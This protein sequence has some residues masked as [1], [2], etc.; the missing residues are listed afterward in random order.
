MGKITCGYEA[1]LDRRRSSNTELTAR[2]SWPAG[3]NDI[4]IA[5]LPRRKILK[6]PQLRK[7]QHR[8][9]FTASATL[10]D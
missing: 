4:S 9:R 5:L 6:F 8:S 1:H 7:A 10:L 2:H 3:A